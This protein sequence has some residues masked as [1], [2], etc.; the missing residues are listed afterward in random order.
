[1]P[2]YTRAEAERLLPT[3]R[4]L[5][6]DLQRRVAA[7]RRQPSDPVARE[8]EALLREIA[9]LGVEVKDPDKGLIDFR[10]KLRGREVYLCWKIGE[11]DRIAF[12]HDLET[13]F[14]GRKIIED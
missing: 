14:A 6:E 11:G 8:I 9:E 3:V 7:Y 5:V 10:A 2:T 12:W 13:G 1:M 4:P